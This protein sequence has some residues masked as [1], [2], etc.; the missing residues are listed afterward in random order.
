MLLTEIVPEVRVLDLAQVIAHGPV[1]KKT[2]G[3]TAT[4]VPPY[5]GPLIGPRAGCNM[6]R[7]FSGFSTQAV[8]LDATNADATPV[9]L[10]VQ[11]NGACKQCVN[12]S[13]LTQDAQPATLYLLTSST[14]AITCRW[15]YISSVEAAVQW[16][17]HAHGVNHISISAAPAAA[18]QAGRP[19]QRCQVRPDCSV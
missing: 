13:S 7:D 3:R 1:S 17:G 4:A 8:G 9:D 11:C 6:A 2:E 15:M 10:G 18:A 12:H 5:I 19:V 16:V 14:A